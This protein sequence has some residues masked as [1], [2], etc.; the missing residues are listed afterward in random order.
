MSVCV[1]N[2]HNENEMKNIKVKFPK[3]LFVYLHIL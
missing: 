1:H 2:M 3:N